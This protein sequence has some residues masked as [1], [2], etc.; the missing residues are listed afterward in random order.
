MS[1]LFCVGRVLGL[2]LLNLLRRTC[3]LC[4]RVYG[5][6]LLLNGLSLLFVGNW[7]WDVIRLSGR[8]LIGLTCTEALQQSSKQVFKQTHLDEKHRVSTEN[9]GSGVRGR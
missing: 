3:W 5:G 2:R 4:R 9:E 8:P 6:R 7:R 1:Y